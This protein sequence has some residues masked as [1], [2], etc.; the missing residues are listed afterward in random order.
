MSNCLLISAAI[1]HNHSKPLLRNR[2]DQHILS[3]F[4]PSLLTD[5]SLLCHT[6]FPYLYLF[7]IMHQSWMH[8]GEGVV[9]LVKKFFTAFD[10]SLSVLKF[11]S[12]ESQL[13]KQLRTSNM[14]CKQSGQ[15]SCMQTGHFQDW[16][17]HLSHHFGSTPIQD[18][19][20]SHKRKVDKEPT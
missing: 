20:S 8:Y 9:I 4:F 13:N 5:L 10:I 6:T 3:F 2:G 12:P 1:S 15:Y 17:A 18:L 7:V 14:L 16:M 19:P 11:C